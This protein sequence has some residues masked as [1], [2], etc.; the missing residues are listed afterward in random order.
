MVGSQIVGIKMLYQQ[1]Q[2]TVFVDI[3]ETKTLLSGTLM[4]R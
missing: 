4:R 1:L 3:G 2:Q